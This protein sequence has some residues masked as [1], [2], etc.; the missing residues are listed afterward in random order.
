MVVL[1]LIN[2]I[3]HRHSAERI[4]LVPDGL[5]ARPA[6]ETA[7]VKTGATIGDALRSP[8]FWLLSLSVTRTGLCNMTMVVHQTR[9]LVDMGYSLALASL[10]FDMLWR[11]PGAFEH[12]THGAN[13]CGK[14]CS[15]QEQRASL[16]SASSHRLW[17]T[18]RPSASPVRCRLGG[19]SG[20]RARRPVRS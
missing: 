8:V 4:G 1:I 2:L 9:L 18:H 10:I 16:S 14:K 15:V 5:S 19:Q 12:P 13:H 20:E 11:N 3:F 6:T 7:P 17:R